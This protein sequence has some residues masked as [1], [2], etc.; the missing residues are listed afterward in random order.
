MEEITFFVE[1]EPDGGFVAQAA[2]H[3]M[4]TQADTR[5]ELIKNVRELI[6]V[7]FDRPEDM[8][9]K[10]RLHFVREEVFAI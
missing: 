6:E 10:V 3:G 4:V 8:P 7:Y 5:E 9:K 1:Q 2:G